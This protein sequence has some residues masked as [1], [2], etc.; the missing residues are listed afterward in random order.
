MMLEEVS[1]FETSV[2]LYPTARCNTPEY[3]IFNI[4]RRVN[5]ISHRD[6]SE[7]EIEATTDYSV[8]CDGTLGI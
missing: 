3:S 7:F 2:I 4:H 5:L 8:L 6:T 1:I